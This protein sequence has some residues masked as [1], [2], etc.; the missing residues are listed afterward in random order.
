MVA[1]ELATAAELGLAPIFVV[2]VDASLALIELKQRQRQ[3]P[4]RR[5]R[6]RAARFCRHGPR[7]WRQ[8]R[9]RQNTRASCA[10]RLHEA[11]DAD[12]FTVIAAVIERGAYDGRI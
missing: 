3:L 4:N 10:Q 5:R 1:G 7:L 11:H 2:F 12:T 8:W 9:T 6:F